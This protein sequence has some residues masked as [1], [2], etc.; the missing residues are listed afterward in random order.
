[1]PQSET[2]LRPVPLLDLK[3][4]YSSIR[5]EVLARLGELFESQQFILGREVEAF[6]REL[7]GYCSVPFAIGCAS[8]SDA[9]ILALRA[10]GIGRGDK[11]LTTPYSFF[12]TAGSIAQTGA[13]PVFADVDPA[14]FNLDPDQV[15]RVGG[16]RAIIAVHLY[17]GCADMDRIDESA[18][19]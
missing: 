13:T 18:R 10:L 8:G 3:P 16:V 17:G 5:A 19:G 11:V 1:M 12:A 6:E 7:A 9:L 15:A 14:T 4:Q 2:G